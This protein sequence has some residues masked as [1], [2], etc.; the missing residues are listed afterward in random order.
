MKVLPKIFHLNGH[1]ISVTDPWE[2]PRMGAPLPLIFRPN[3]GPNGRKKLFWRPG[4]P[5]LRVWMTTP[6]YLND[7]VGIRVDVIAVLSIF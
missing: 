4:P 5:Y 7:V 6:P 1:T 2:G 3:G